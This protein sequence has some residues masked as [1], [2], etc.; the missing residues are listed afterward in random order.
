MFVTRLISGIILLVLTAIFLYFGGIPLL[1]VLAFLSVIGFLE[2]TKA[3]GI[4]RE[5]GNFNRLEF[6]GIVGN[7]L[8]YTCQMYFYFKQEAV[9][10]VYL[11]GI[12]VFTI[13][14]MLAV[15]VVSFP[16]FNAT[17][18]VGAVFAFL[19]VPVMLSFIGMTRALPEIGN[20]VVWMIWI[21]AWG[22][23]TCAYCVGMLTGKT[24]GNHKAFPVLSPKKSI[25]GCIGGVVGSVLLGM[26]FG[27]FVM[28]SDYGTI[29][30][31]II[32]GIGSVIAQCGDLAASA[33]KRNYNIKDYGK[34][35]PGHGGILDRFDSIIFTAP[36]IYFLIYFFLDIKYVFMY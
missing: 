30:M 7:I 27:H 32:C 5:N 31:G 20:K 24:I 3:I 25:E 1:A 16:K 19:Y 14:A 2:M 13:I 23:D 22:S 26:L 17:Q 18:A 33:I 9:D 8:L 10:V 36:C 11:L 21:S 12:I 35:I 6:T 34:C 28:G 15:Y 4:T 29:L